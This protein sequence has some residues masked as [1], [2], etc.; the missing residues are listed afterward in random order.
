MFKVDDN[1][2]YTRLASQQA[3]NGQNPQ[4]A[5]TP[6]TNVSRVLRNQST[7]HELHGWCWLVFAHWR[8]LQKS[9]PNAGSPSLYT[10]VWPS[11]PRHSHDR[12]LVLPRVQ[13]GVLR[14]DDPQRKT[15]SRC[16][17]AGEIRR[18][19]WLYS[20]VTWRNQE[21]MVALT[22]SSHDFARTSY[23]EGSYDSI[24]HSSL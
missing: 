10:P 21:T 20:F 13:L 12:P 9:L 24:E 1:R 18:V 5:I 14:P 23:G 7:H 2:N 6:F 16:A 22:L 15:A 4:P 8:L 3:C 11:F 17:T 19:L